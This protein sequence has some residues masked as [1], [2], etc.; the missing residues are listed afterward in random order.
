MPRGL[1]HIVHVVRDLDAAADFYR[2]AGFTVG[3]RNRHP[4]GTH[5]H[6]VQF[7]GFFIEILTVAEPDK[8]GDDG[9]SRYFG[10]PNREAIARGDEG[11][12][13]LVLESTDSEA[14]MA[15]FA[16]SGIGV[17]QALPF[18]REAKLPDGSAT[19]V[20]FAL[21]FAK[22]ARSPHTG[23]FTC[24][25]HNPAAFWKPDYQQHANGASGV[26]GAVLAASNP[27][28]HHIF[29]KAFTGVRDLHA[30]SMGVVAHTPRGDVEIMEQVAFHDQFGVTPKL[31]GEGASLKGLRLAVPN[32][33]RIAR[34]LKD[35]GIA[36]RRHVGRLVVPPEAAFGATLIFEAPGRI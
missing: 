5:N 29:L 7:P 32:I 4:W 31:D 10:S 13:M 35:G 26:L 21:V 6:V 18:S 17:S 30:S 33:D 27:A 34:V 19:T 3:A 36:S 8:L 16:R 25:Q 9:L 20:G 1:D 11:F 22:D 24:R 23:F 2:S 14:D 12:S 28:D 15:D